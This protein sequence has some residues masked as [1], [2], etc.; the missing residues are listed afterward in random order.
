MRPAT[1][2]SQRTSVVLLGATLIAALS[3]VYAWPFIVD[4]AFITF[5][6]AGNL[7]AGGGYAMNSGVVTDGVTGP[8]WLLPLALGGALGV[9]IPLVAQVVGILFALAA[10]AL[11]LWSM[12]VRSAGRA[13]EVSALFLALSGT[14]WVWASGGLETG[15]ATFAM[16]VLVASVVRPMPKWAPVL[17]LG[18]LPGLRPELFPAAFL[19]ALHARGLPRRWALTAAIAG[20]AGIG[21]WRL[22]M[23]GTPIPLSVM[24]KGG[25]LVDGARYILSGVLLMTMGGGLYLAWRARKRRAARWIG[26]A[27]LIHLGVV[28]LAGGDWMPGHRLLVP[29]LPA[30]AL[31]VGWGC[32]A[33]RRAAFVLA[34]TLLMSVWLSAY[35][36]REAREAGV[37]RVTHGGAIAATLENGPVALLDAGYLGWE[38]GLEVVDLGGITDPMVA[39]MSGNHVD[40]V[41][42]VAYLEQR[43]PAMFVLHSVT[44][45]TIAD[46]EVG[47][48]A[49]YPTENRLAH[50]PWFKRSYVPTEVHAYGEGYWYVRFERRE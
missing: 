30:L 44:E 7:V 29:V 6:Y 37:R 26:L 38:S 11:M 9:P 14:N 20:V 39:R 40:R 23:F 27:L 16:T 12:T 43:A 49:G 35:T 45:P 10:A 25:S 31:L 32:T 17:A 42:D 47:N 21:V 4:D 8:L 13:R 22:V 18:I 3:S 2:K 48:F 19:L 24:A 1:P 5:R 41:L 28:G 46:G 15:A 36:L 33:Y 50:S 34:P